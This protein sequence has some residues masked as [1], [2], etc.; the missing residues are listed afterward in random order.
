MGN[1]GA[2]KGIE[3][4]LV[5]DAYKVKGGKESVLTYGN[6][7]VIYT[8]EAETADEYIAKATDNLKKEGRVTVAT[9]DGLVQMIIFGSGATRLSAADLYREVLFTEEKM[10]EEHSKI[11]TQE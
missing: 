8:K 11:L 5:F 6:L 2:Y 3:T 10:R 1:Y 7:T 9:S 4:I